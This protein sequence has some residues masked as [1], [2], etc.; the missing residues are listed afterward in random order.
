[1]A[2]GT[3]NTR[4][5]QRKGNNDGEITFGHL[6]VRDGGISAVMI[7][8][9]T[10]TTHF[11]SLEEMKLKIE[12]QKKIASNKEITIDTTI[13]GGFDITLDIIAYCCC[14]DNLLR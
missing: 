6:W 1:M 2:S 10:D 12:Q 4:Y 9:M 14:A 13:A 8:N 5:C 3:D 7:R 11:M